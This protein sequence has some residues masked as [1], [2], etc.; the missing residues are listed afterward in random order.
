[1]SRPWTALIVA[2]AL[3]GGCG[4]DAPTT[5]QEGSAAAS[6]AAGQDGVAATAIPGGVLVPSADPATFSPAKRDYVAAATAACDRSA[7]EIETATTGAGLTETSS[8]DQIIGFILDSYVPMY[9]QRLDALAALTPPPEDGD[10]MTRLLTDSRDHLDK[11]VADPAAFLKKDP[12]DAVDV[13]F[14]TYGLAACGS[15]SG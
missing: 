4:D 8:P 7:A 9:R 2:A 14:D 1:V 5:A 15:R 11:L 6:E 12:F 13:G 10:R 3:L